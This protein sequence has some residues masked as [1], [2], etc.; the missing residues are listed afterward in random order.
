LLLLMLL[1]PRPCQQILVVNT[2]MTQLAIGRSVG[3]AANQ[4]G[5]TVPVPCR[6]VPVRRP[7]GRQ[8]TML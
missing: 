8:Q 5:S 4:P 3:R 7:A 2:P 1:M 6:A